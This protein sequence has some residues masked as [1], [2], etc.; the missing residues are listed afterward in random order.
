MDGPV[1]GPGGCGALGLGLPYVRAALISSFAIGSVGLM[2]LLCHLRRE[3]PRPVA[4]IAVLLTFAATPLYWYMVYEPSMTHAASFGFVALFVVAAARW[5]PTSATDSRIPTP[6][7]RHALILGTLIGLA[8]LARSQESL[9]AL[10]PGILALSAV[11]VPRSERVRRAMRLA[12]WAFLGALPWI[13]L[14]LGHSYILFTR[15]EYDLLGQGGYFN[16]LQ[17]RWI[18][19]LFSSWHGFLSWTPVAYIAVIGTIAYLRREWRWALSA[20]LILFITAWVNGATED[21]AGGWSFGG[22]RF[23]SALAMLAPGLAVVIGFALR[24]PLV[25]LAPLVVGALAVDAPADGP[26]HRGH[27]AQGRARQLRP[28]R[29]QQAA[30]HT[31]PP[32]SLS[33]R[34]PGQRAVCV[35]RG[36][37]GGQVRCVVAAD[38]AGL[39]Q[40]DV[41]S[42]SREVP[43]RRME[44]PGGDD[45]GEARRIG[46]SPR[47]ARAVGAGARPRSP[48]PRDCERAFKSRYAGVDGARRERGRGGPLPAR[49]ARCQ[50]GGLSRSPGTSRADCFSADSTRWRFAAWA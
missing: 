38:T 32:L 37:A 47:W 7:S 50:H 49:C 2:A 36:R 4:F 20:L 16:P 25:A 41:P 10:Y 14:Q 30:L 5:I 6:D 12:L 48:S 24:R 35:A 34:V 18:D 1:A 19:T 28:H 13:L 39:L 17:S 40:P 3:F 33:V 43:A 21:W 23:S 22:R 8:F 15:Y 45:L 11:G 46:D 26:V 9:F 42:R 29:P 31:R 44:A 27:A